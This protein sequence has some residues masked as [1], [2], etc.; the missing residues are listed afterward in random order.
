M[1]PHCL[2]YAAPRVR[3]YFLTAGVVIAMDVA[4]WW[5][6]RS[7][8]EAHAA[9]EGW[10]GNELQ[11]AVMAWAE[12]NRPAARSQPDVPVP[13]LEPPPTRPAPVAPAPVPAAISTVSLAAVPPLPPP[14]AR[15]YRSALQDIFLAAGQY[16]A[17]WTVGK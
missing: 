7:E 4:C 9:A 15:R 16:S 2:V 10:D 8:V 17:H 14:S 3:H 1:M 6:E 5:G 11:S 12:A 13:L